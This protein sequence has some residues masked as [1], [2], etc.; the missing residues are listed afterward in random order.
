MDT[1]QKNEI[2]MDEIECPICS[3]TGNG[4]LCTCLNAA[5]CK[6]PICLDLQERIEKMKNEEI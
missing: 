1:I 5:L 3:N 6:C 2:K 4:V